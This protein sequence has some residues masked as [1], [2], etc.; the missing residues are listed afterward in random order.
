MAKYRKSEQLLDE[1]I[2]Y[3]KQHPNATFRWLEGQFKV[4]K[5][6]ICRRW[7]ETQ[8]ARK[9]THGLLDLE[10]DKALVQYCYR[11]S[12]IGVPLRHKFIRNAANQ[13]LQQAHGDRPGSPP[14]PTAGQNWPYRWLKVHPELKKFKQEHLE[15]ERKRAMDHDT[16]KHFFDEF[17]RISTIRN[18]PNCHK[19]NMDETGLRIGV[20]RGQWVIIPNTPEY[21]GRFSQHL[22]SLMIQSICLLL[23]QSQEMVEQLLHC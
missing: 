18:I 3:K 19:W 23:S 16:I 4:K 6:R 9:R 15:T 2:E 11:L 10:Q 20:G 22:A 7:N 12:E 5:D 1:A 8:E 14:P 21:I 13:I 17:Y